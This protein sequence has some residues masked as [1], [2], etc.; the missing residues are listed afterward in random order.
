MHMKK[1]CCKG[2]WINK[3]FAGRIRTDLGSH[4]NGYWGTSW[5]WLQ[6]TVN[7]MTIVWHYEN[8]YNRL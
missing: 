8:D 5:Q 4:D 6:Q 1:R 3:Y 2:K 7:A